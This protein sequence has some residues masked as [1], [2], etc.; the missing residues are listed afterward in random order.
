MRTQDRQNYILDT[1]KEVGFV[2]I[3]EAAKHLDVSTE[4]VRRDIQKLSEKNLL[5]KVRGGA[6]PVK[7]PFKND[8][9]YFWRSR[10]NKHEKIAIGM[11]AA[12]MVKSN[13]F[14]AFSTGTS[15]QAVAECISGVENVTFATNSIPIAMILLDKIEAGEIGG[16]V[17]LC[18]GELDAQ[19]RFTYGSNTI[20]E[21]SKL[22][23]DIAFVSC[24]AFSADGTSTYFEHIYHPI[25]EYVIRQTDISVLVAESA[26]MGKVSTYRFAKLNDFDRIITD[27]KNPIPQSISETLA[28]SKTELTVVECTE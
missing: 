26:K 2:S 16:Q 20:N 27:N 28:N 7:L 14:V 12:K 18:G 13:M 21:I 3:I 24:T 1:A 11:E 6:A 25:H 8:G 9:E 5:K 15:V 22:H 19:S 23:F 4:T 10:H 17:I